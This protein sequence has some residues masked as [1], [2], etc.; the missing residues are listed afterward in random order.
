MFA[1]RALP[2]ALAVALLAPRVRAQAL[3]PASQGNRIGLETDLW[4]SPD[5]DVLIWQLAAQIKLTSNLY[6]DAEAPYKDAG[7][8][9][10]VGPFASQGPGVE[11]IFGNPSLGAHYATF[12]HR[13]IA[14]FAGGSFTIPTLLSSDA[15]QDAAAAIA[16]Y[17][18]AGYESERFEVETF[19][20]RARV[21]LEARVASYLLWRGELVPV[22]LF[23]F[24]NDNLALE[25]RTVYFFPETADEIEGRA[26]CGFGGGLR[27][28][29]MLFLGGSFAE[30][31]SGAVEPY[32]AY[33]PTA[34]GVFVRIGLLVATNE[35]YGFGLDKDKVAT[36]RLR[37]GGKW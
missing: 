34:A 4:A 29:A 13:D 30:R 31:F 16:N 24:G 26:D 9:P 18:T 27:V 15:A 37:I 28:Q 25:K 21:G 3:Q 8:L 36:A 12:F 14:F 10:R 33:E 23:P 20:T 22:L 5:V 35:P 19:S 2:A 1:R 7:L 6:V 17:P 11:G 32:I